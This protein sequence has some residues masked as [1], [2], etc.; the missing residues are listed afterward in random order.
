MLNSEARAWAMMLLAV[1]EI[2]IAGLQKLASTNRL[3]TLSALFRADL[4]PNQSN[5]P[6]VRSDSGLR[7][8]VAATRRHPRR[9]RWW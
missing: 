4:T 5:A 2:Q 1:G 9:P 7:C 3:S 6:C 8:S